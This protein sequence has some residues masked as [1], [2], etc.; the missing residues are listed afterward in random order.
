MIMP[1]LSA[2]AVVVAD[3]WWLRPWADPAYRAKSLPVQP[4]PRST[5][6]W[7]VSTRH[8]RSSPGRYLR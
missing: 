4:R 7:F 2:T 1:C 8:K 6:R 3:L 5:K